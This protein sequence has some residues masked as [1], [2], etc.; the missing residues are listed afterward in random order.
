MLYLVLIGWLYVVAMITLVSDSLLKDVVRL[1][2]LGVL[3]LA[4]VVG[5]KLLRRRAEMD[6][7]PTDSNAPP[8]QPPAG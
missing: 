7:A 1:L 5:I 2:F 8:A 4:I 3:P 6:A